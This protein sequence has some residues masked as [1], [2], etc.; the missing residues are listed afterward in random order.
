M[1]LQLQREE[2]QA[3]RAFVE[4]Q[5]STVGDNAW[6]TE[7]LMWQ[8][9]LDK[10]NSEIDELAADHRFFASVAL[11]FDGAPVIGSRDIRLDF[12]TDALERYQRIVALALA[13]RLQGHLARR[14][15]VR[16]SDKA[17]LYIREIARGSMGFVLEE[18]PIEQPDMF[19]SPSTL[20][21]AVEDSTALIQHLSDADEA[22]FD[23]LL[24]ATH[25]RMVNAIQSFT[26]TLS[27]AAASTRILGDYQTA[28]LTIANIKDLYLKLNDVITSD[29]NE[30]VDGLVL[31][32]FPD[33]LQFEFRPSTD[34]EAIIRGSITDDLAEKYVADSSF[35]DALLMHPGRATMKVSR[36]VRGGRIVKEARLLEGW[37]FIA[38]LST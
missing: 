23:H 14:G 13:E 34:Q 32:V 7:R 6:G 18:L 2:L 11:I 35:R 10:L 16:G 31:G 4:K 12:A 36:T 19:E 20:K 33:A 30:Q 8:N 15:P 25:P 37:E 1:P 38:L 22:D 27:E 21:V 5:I 28:T 17:R 3:E 26:K 9:R 24:E 29:D